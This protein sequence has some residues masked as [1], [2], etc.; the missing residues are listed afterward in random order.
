MIAMKRRAFVT[1]LA[2]V[3]TAPAVSGA[4]LLAAKLWRVGVLAGLEVDRGSSDGDA[5]LSGLKHY[6][7]IEGK[8][9][10]VERRVTRGANERAA[11][12]AAELVAGNVDV[13][14]TVGGHAAHAAKQATTTV[15]IVSIVVSDHV[16]AGL[17][18]SRKR[19]GGNL[20]GMDV[21]ASDL[22]PKLL[23]LLQEMIPT[24]SRVSV[25]GLRSGPGHSV[26]DEPLS[27]AAR[28]I[29]ISLHRAEVASAQEYPAAFADIVRSRSDGIL[30]LPDPT[31][32]AA[33]EQICGFARQR[34]L[35][36]V[37]VWPYYV[38]SGCL[39]MYGP[40][41]SEIFRR[42]VTLSIAFSAGRIPVKSRSK[43]RRGMSWLSTSRPPEPSTSR[44]LNR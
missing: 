36:T 41:R 37:A 10:I 29:R 1:G 9:I 19:P 35:P 4:H 39:L 24:L 8:N 27:H 43:S 40:V 11:A 6:G 17:A 2:A 25:L 13:L 18:E 22:T 42:A 15:P 23:T 33:R 38:E 32:A 28:A 7:Y 44:L 31:N 5:F 30:V 34:R 21:V 3:M 26:L 16:R 12:L 14:V 20:T